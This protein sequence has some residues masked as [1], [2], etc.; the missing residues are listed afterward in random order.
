MAK[1][2]VFEDKIKLIISITESFL[3]IQKKM[4]KS[5]RWK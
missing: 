3:K 2:I 1:K 4:Y 5:Y